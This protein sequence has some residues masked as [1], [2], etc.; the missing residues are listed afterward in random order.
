MAQAGP[1]DDRRVRSCGC[2]GKAG[3]PQAQ[4]PVQ[5]HAALDGLR[6][7]LDVLCP[8]HL[9]LSPCGDVIHVGPTLQKLRAGLDMAGRPFLDLFAVTRPRRIDTAAAFSQ[10]RGGKMRLVFRDPPRTTF[11]A[12]L[13]PFGGGS[14]LNLSFGISIMDALGDYA[15]SSA[16]FAAT[17]MT[18][19]MLYLFEAKSAAMEES[20]KLNLRLRGAMV[21]AEAQALTDTL[22][23]L[24]NRRALDQRLARLERER[25]GFALMHLDLDLFK[26][27][28]DTFGHAAGD[29]VLRH[30]AA[31]LTGEMRSG[32]LAARIGGDEFVLLFP[33]L[34]HPDQLDRL[35]RRII[36]RISQPVPYGNNLCRISCSAGSVLS[37]DYDAPDSA[38]M[39]ADADQALYAAKRD[40][41]G[42][43]RFFAS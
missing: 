43:H 3:D 5:D 2:R 20:R 18:V 11:K 28:N 29:H 22:T 14:V 34:Q 24:A 6:P 13:V 10:L 21:A 7:V 42:C 39:L 9:L 12:S 4:S 36:E 38:R 30:V 17:D 37:G 23:G 31:I 25:D 35:A 15:L 8:M 33:G 19:E 40:G 41:R 26:A 16:D 32:D 27:V 1:T